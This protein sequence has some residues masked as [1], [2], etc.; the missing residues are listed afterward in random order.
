MPFSEVWEQ[1]RTNA[2]TDVAP[3]PSVVATV[4]FLALTLRVERTGLRR[5]IKVAVALA[6]IWMTGVVAERGVLEK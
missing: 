2:W 4:L 5:T 1:S 3:I 6:A